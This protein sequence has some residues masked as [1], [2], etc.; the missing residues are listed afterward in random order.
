M[1]S[2][3]HHN[4][5]QLGQEMRAFNSSLDKFQ[6]FLMRSKSLVFGSAMLAASALASTNALA[7]ATVQV[8]AGVTSVALSSVF[9]GALTSLGV[10]PSPLAP[11]TLTGATANFPVTGGAVDADTAKG[12]IDHSGGLILTAGSTVVTLSNF[13][14]TYSGGSHAV[15][16]GIVTANGTLLGRY[17]LF[18]VAAGAT[19]PLTPKNGF[20]VY[21]PNAN[22]TL[23]ATAAGLLNGAFNVT[24][25]TAGIPIGT[26]DVSVLVAY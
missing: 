5:C 20:Y 12:E 1:Q 14:I 7:Q 6:E 22:L 16:S 21:V 24:A 25:F 2:D 9:T 19:L 11:A 17:A 23:S 8:G 26:A 10:T 18:N 13:D 4:R 15:L 3:G